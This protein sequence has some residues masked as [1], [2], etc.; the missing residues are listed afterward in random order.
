MQWSREGVQPILQIRA[1][2]SSNDWNKNWEKYI[3]NAYLKA[4]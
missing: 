2:S 1:A 4:A 3:L